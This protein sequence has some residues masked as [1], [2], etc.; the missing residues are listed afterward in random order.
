MTRFEQQYMEWL[1]SKLE[2]E[3]NPRRKELLGKGL[4]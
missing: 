2:N 1:K 3:S 4:G